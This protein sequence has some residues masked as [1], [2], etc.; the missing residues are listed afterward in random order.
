MNDCVL[1]TIKVPGARF[2]LHWFRGSLLS[3]PE[4]SSSTLDGGAS[5]H[6]HLNLAAHSLASCW[7]MTRGAVG[8]LALAETKPFLTGAWGPHWSKAGWRLRTP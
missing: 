4:N 7:G 3:T 6:Q 1:R 8:E 5:V 2:P